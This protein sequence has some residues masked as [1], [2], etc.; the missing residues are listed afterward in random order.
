MSNATKFA[1]GWS[2]A[3]NWNLV[4]ALLWKEI[5]IFLYICCCILQVYV[6]P[7]VPTL[8]SSCFGGEGT[9]NILCHPQFV[10]FGWGKVFANENLPS[11]CLVYFL[12]FRHLTLVVSYHLSW[13]PFLFL[14]SFLF[15]DID[16]GIECHY[17]CF[18]IHEFAPLSGL[19]EV[20]VCF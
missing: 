5:L 15:E 2:M 1:F 10:S 13:F 18:F 4:E 19:L 12:P 7:V 6:G 3:A 8:S 9:N 20:F 17:F 16:F 11:F 14:W